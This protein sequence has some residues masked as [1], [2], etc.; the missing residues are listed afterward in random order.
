M[1]SYRQYTNDNVVASKLVTVQCLLQLRVGETVDFAC[2][3][4]NVWDSLS[5]AKEVPIADYFKKNGLRMSYTRLNDEDL[6]CTAT[7]TIGRRVL[8]KDVKWEP[9]LY[10]VPNNYWYPLM[11]GAIPSNGRF[12]WEGL[13]PWCEFHP[14]TL[15]GYR[16]PFVL[17]SDLKN[18]PP[19]VGSS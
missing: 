15:V 18:L 7:L 10:V 8:W 6:Q 19:V 14:D 1:S 3:D 4:R 13:K 2:L 16:G 5:P 12:L 9:H 11:D 17:W